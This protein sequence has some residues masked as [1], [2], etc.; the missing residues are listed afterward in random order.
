MRYLIF[1][2]PLALLLLTTLG[3]QK[4]IHEARGPESER[5]ITMDL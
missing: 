4:T 3:C 1:T 5:V 2:L